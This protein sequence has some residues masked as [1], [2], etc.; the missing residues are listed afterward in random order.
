MRSKI[1]S[2]E[3]FHRN[4]PQLP[5]ATTA[6]RIVFRYWIMPGGDEG[7]IM[8]TSTTSKTTVYAHVNHGRWSVRCPWCNSSQ[9]ASRD[10]HRFFCVEC[11]NAAVSG[12]WVTVVW[13]NEVAA[14]EEVLSKRPDVKNHNWLPGESVADLVADNNEHGVV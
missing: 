11:G 13:P 7:R 3:N 5:G 4:D 2:A 10:D 12:Q 6:Q 14:I 1:R 8:P 9:N